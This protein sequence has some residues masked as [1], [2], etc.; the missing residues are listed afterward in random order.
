MYFPDAGPQHTNE[1]LAIAKREALARGVKFVVVASTVGDTGVLA[2]ELF[3]GTGIGVVVVTHN[4]GFKEPGRQEFDD[5]KLARIRE[6]GGAVLTGTHILRGLGAAI[7]S[8]EGFSE[9]LLVAAVLRMFGQGIKVCVEIAAM[10]ADAGLVPPED[11]IAVAGTGR[12]ADTCA[13]VKADSSNRFFD[14]RVREIF[15]KPG[16]F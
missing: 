15:A 14:I 2:A 6:L 8:R 5:G 1:T 11:V 13:L 16:K 4:T 9:E 10:A 7:R 3:H 12:G